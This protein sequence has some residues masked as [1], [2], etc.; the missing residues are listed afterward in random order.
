LTS[1]ESPLQEAVRIQREKDSAAGKAFA[2][3]RSPTLLRLVYLLLGLAAAAGVAV[4]Y[5]RGEQT[6][7]F[8]ISLSAFALLVTLGI[9][10]AHVTRS[11][12]VESQRRYQARLFIRNL[13][14][15]DMAMRDDLTQL[16]NRRYFYERLQR[17]LEQAHRYQRPLAVVVLD[18]DGLKTMNDVYGHKAGDLVLATMGRLLVECTRTCDVPARIGGDEFGVIMPETDKSGAFA[19]ARRLQQ[20]VEAGSAIEE[21]GRKHKLRV[22]MGVSG[23]PWGGDDVDQIVQW[24][25]TYMYAAKAARRNQ[26]SSTTQKSCCVKSPAPAGDEAHEV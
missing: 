19:V 16:F 14:L 4:A 22:S 15:Q 9:V 7:Q 17:E 11:K 6:L 23:F 26:G 8:A 20:G 13:E 5:L 12:L 3:P 21:N 1:I 10:M 2:S 24:A 25:D 18:V